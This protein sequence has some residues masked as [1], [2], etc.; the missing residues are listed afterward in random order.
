MLS[1]EPLGSQ[2]VDAAYE[3]NSEFVQALLVCA[4]QDKEQWE[5]WRRDDTEN[6]AIHWAVI[7]KNLPMLILL[8]ENG[9]DVHR[10][11]KAGKTPL[12]LALENIHIEMAS[13]LLHYDDKTDLFNALQAAHLTYLYNPLRLEKALFE[14]DI[15][16]VKLLL[17]YNLLNQKLL[18]E[19]QTPLELAIKY[20]QKA[21]VQYLIMQGAKINNIE[22]KQDQEILRLFSQYASAESTLDAIMIQ[23]RENTEKLSEFISMRARSQENIQ[24]VDIE[25]LTFSH[26]IL[27]AMSEILKNLHSANETMTANEKMDLVI[28]IKSL[29]NAVKTAETKPQF[30]EKCKLILAE[31]EDAILNTRM[32]YCYTSHSL[33]NQL[34]LLLAKRITDKDTP[35]QN[36]LLT[37]ACTK[38]RFV[39]NDGENVQITWFD[40]S[41]GIEETTLPEFKDFFRL[42]G[43]EIHLY[44]LVVQMAIVRLKDHNKLLEHIWFGTD[45]K[46]ITPVPPLSQETLALLKQKSPTLKKLI[47]HTEFLDKHTRAISESDVYTQ[48]EILQKGLLA[49]NYKVT[50]SHQTAGSAA[51]AAIAAFADWWNTLKNHSPALCE[52][53]RSLSHEYHTENGTSIETFGSAI[54]ILFDQ[55]NLDNNERRDNANYCIHLKANRIERLLGDEN[56]VDALHN[57][58]IEINEMKMDL[59]SDKPLDQWESQI[60]EEIQEQASTPIFVGDYGKFPSDIPFLELNCLLIYS[61][62]IQNYHDIILRKNKHDDSKLLIQYIFSEN[63]NNN[64]IKLRNILSNSEFNYLREHDANS[65]YYTFSQGERTKTSH[66]YALIHKALAEQMV[67]NVVQNQTSKKDAN[68]VVKKLCEENPFI[69]CKTKDNYFGLFFKQKSTVS[70]LFEGYRNF[71]NNKKELMNQI[72]RVKTQIS[73]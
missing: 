7:N 64:L 13:L 1:Q 9:A 54:D 72:A 47:E 65:K 29:L 18:G 19:K 17:N 61:G 12:M 38:D 68:A 27:L 26:E 23:E 11:N 59:V 28:L 52:K 46:N 67:F 30:I 15:K 57:I 35:P 6:H 50:G 49:G 62:F 63:D 56:I 70:T 31:R 44:Q 10:K 36:I 14:N 4:K 3:N 51:Y 22:N 43:N 5:N 24:K 42:P 55:N 37:N 41:I 69:P 32:D 58:N 73:L 53:I 39:S 34:C 60:T 2:I 33:A 45:P 40:P 8:L 48:F 20:N 21:I 71:E 66:H 16:T 25:Y